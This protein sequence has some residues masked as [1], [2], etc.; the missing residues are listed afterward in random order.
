[1]NNNKS[2][3]ATN[4]HDGD[5]N[6]VRM[7]HLLPLFRLIYVSSRLMQILGQ[8]SL[9]FIPMLVIKESKASC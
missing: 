8:W 2:L 9:F 4:M 1:M 7:S 3:I 6:N 5:W